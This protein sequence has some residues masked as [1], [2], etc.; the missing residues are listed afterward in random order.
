MNNRYQ[1]EVQTKLAKGLLYMIVLQY[2][3][4][5]PMHGYQL[6]TT[7]KKGFGVNFGPSTIY[8]LLGLLEKKGY[9]Q[10]SWDMN[11]EKPRKIFSL[12]QDGKQALSF[13][14]NTLLMIL[15]KITQEPKI[16]VRVDSSMLRA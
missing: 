11:H 13:T 15:Q 8:P 6:I 1:K 10:S 14:E 7:I 5:A 2:L 16:Q 4:S 9:I 12:T 3:D